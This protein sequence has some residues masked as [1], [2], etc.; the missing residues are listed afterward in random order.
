LKTIKKTSSLII[1][2][3]LSYNEWV[4][5]VFKLS[6]EHLSSEEYEA[7]KHGY[8]KT[9]TGCFGF[10]LMSQIIIYNII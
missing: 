8:T 4:D 1:Y 6:M 7:L 5:M 10:L 3:D 2:N 9:K